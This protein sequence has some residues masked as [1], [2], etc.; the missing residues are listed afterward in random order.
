MPGPA[1]LSDPSGKGQKEMKKAIE[2]FEAAKRTK[3]PEDLKKAGDFKFN[4]YRSDDV[5]RALE[6][7]FLGKCAYCESRY[8]ATQP[9]DV[10]HWRPKG[11]VLEED[12]SMSMGYYWLAATWDNLFPA[13]ID[14][15]RA[16]LQESAVDKTMVLL[17]KGNHFPIEPATTRADGPT[18]VDVP[19]LLN[20]CVDEPLEHITFDVSQAIVKHKTSKGQ[21]SIRVYGLNRVGL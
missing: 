6:R 2:L 16:R 18:K 7:M 14:C 20:P 15:N 4:A 13:C 17:G 11:A 21:K 8:T 19:L 10:E 9:M 3:R 12:D 1:V 5:K